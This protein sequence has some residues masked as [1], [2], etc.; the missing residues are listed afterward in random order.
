VQVVKKGKTIEK[1]MC[2]RVCVCVCE[3]ESGCRCVRVC[4]VL[5]TGFDDYGVA[6]VSRIDKS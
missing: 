2:V 5:S 4:A 3:R 6:T 1:L